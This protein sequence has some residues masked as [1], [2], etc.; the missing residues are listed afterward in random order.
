M[1]SKKN[2]RDYSFLKYTVLIL[3]MSSIISFLMTFHVDPLPK[4]LLEGEVAIKDIK[5]DQN[6]E[7]VDEKTTQ[8]LRDEAQSRILPIYDFDTA[9]ETG[10]RKKVQEAFMA[11]RAQLNDLSKNEVDEDEVDEGVLTEDQELSLKKL[12]HEK[13]GQELDSEDYKI[14]RAAKF[15]LSLEQALSFMINQSLRDPLIHDKSQLEPLI[16][17]GFTLRTLSARDQ[18]SEDAIQNLSGFKDLK[19]AEALLN[20]LKLVDVP[21]LITDRE[22]KKGEFLLLKKLAKSFL[23]PNISYNALETEQRQEKAAANIKNIVFKIKQGESIIRSGDRFEAWHLIVIEGI[24]QARLKTNAWLKFLGVFFFINIVLITIYYYSSRYIRKFQPSKK[25]LL[26]LGLNIIVFL[27]VLRLGVAFAVSLQPSLPFNFDL[28]TL[29]FAIPLAAGAMLI[30]FILNSETALIFALVISVFSGVFLENNLELTVFYLLS[31]VFAAH[32]VS[33]VDKRSTLLLSGTLTGLM[34]ALIILSLTLINVVSISGNF[35]WLEIAMSCLA[36]FLGGLFAAAL[37]LIL[38]SL[39]ESIFD[40]T[41]DIKLLEMANLSHPLLKEM[42]VKSPGTYHHSQIVGIL[43]E[44]G[45]QAIGANPLFARVASYYHDIGKMKKPQ[46]FVEN[47]RGGENPHDKLA[48][49]MSSLIIESHVKD[50]IEMAKQ[51]KLPQRI[52][53]MIPQHQGTKLIGYFYNKAKKMQ[54]PS[55]GEVDEKDYRYP[56]P[57]PQT[58]EAGVIMLADTIEAASRSLPEKTPNK[59]RALVEKLVNQ[60]FVDEQ[61]DDCNLTLKD[62]HRISEAFIKILIGIYHQRI[63]YPEG[64]LVSQNGPNKKENE[65][66]LHQQSTSDDSN[67]AQL[68]QR[69]DNQNS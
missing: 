23:K 32:S 17:K 57:K 53:D 38:T 43:A 24:R 7:I 56:G 68:F 2:K 54:D 52:A 15:D 41:T 37:V 45:A 64:A 47:Q 6:Y 48:P 33:R 22:I 10:T 12:F 50:G 40:Y 39:Y 8:Q 60:H 20:N 62:L 27:A 25:D 49:S 66:D 61:L 3:F 26:F 19:E 4:S 16:E 34:N 55:M 59:I 46:Y 29:Y 42:I 14:L 13:L 5:S 30:R 9:V 44:A 67:V 21:D 69:K 35:D 63:E 36:G 11:A 18:T 58:K 31:S 51:Y 1:A 65:S 28:S